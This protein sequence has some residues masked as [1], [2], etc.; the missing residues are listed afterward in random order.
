MYIEYDSKDCPDFRDSGSLWSFNT[1]EF[2]IPS[3]ASLFAAL[4]YNCPRAG[5]ADLGTSGTTSD[6]QGLLLGRGLPEYV[7]DVVFHR[8]YH[9]V[10]EVGYRDT[11]VDAPAYPLTA[12][13]SVSPAVAEEWVASG[14]SR[15]APERLNAVGRRGRRRVSNPQWHGANWLFYDELCLLLGQL[16]SSILPSIDFRI[17]VEILN[18]FSSGVHPRYAR[19]VYWFD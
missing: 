12:L 7:S 15:Y 16:P 19:L 8:Y 13:P 5:H 4:G 1:A 6:A 10:D 18:M 17:A 3:Q 11:H 9:I 2:S 14:R